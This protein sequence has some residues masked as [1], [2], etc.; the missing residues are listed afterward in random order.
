M[1]F[2]ALLVLHIAVLGY[3]LG[4]ELVINS[5]YRYVSWS[6][7]MSFAERSRLMNQVMHADQ[8]VRYALLLQAGVGMALAADVGYFPGGET[9]AWI[10]LAAMVA[11]LSL[12]EVTHRRRNTLVGEQLAAVDRALRYIG[13]LALVVAAL[14]AWKHWPMFQS[15]PTWLA[16]KLLCFAFVMSCGIGIRFALMGFFR[17][18][19]EIA[20]TGST[21][22]REKEIRAIYVRASGVLVLLW[23]GIS[24]IVVLSFYKPAW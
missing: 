16:W 10:A 22:A 6:D 17:V 18:W 14:G 1:I 23:I 20:I 21:P 13:M 7:S 5:T 3:W 15:V 4:S 2:H 24:V 9:L 19:S 8:H 12:V 11:W